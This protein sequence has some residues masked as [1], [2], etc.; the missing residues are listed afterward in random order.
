MIRIY[1]LRH[2]DRTSY[3]TTQPSPDLAVFSSK[4]YAFEPIQS[5]S[6]SYM[7]R[8]DKREI[9]ITNHLDVQS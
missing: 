3:S 6:R 2:T 4:L 1:G 9:D 8:S 7:P 5:A